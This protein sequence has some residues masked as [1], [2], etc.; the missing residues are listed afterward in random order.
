MIEPDRPVPDRP[1][2][3]DELHAYVDD[4]L[5]PARRAAVER[6]LRANPALQQRIDG[7]QAQSETLRDAL[8]FKAQEPVPA[9]LH[10]GRLLEQRIA[11]RRRWAL[12]RPWRVAAAMLLMLGVGAAGGWTLRGPQRMGEVTRLGME[13]AA[14][15]TVFAADPAHPIEIGP[16]NRP[17]LVAWI[18]RQLHRQLNVP[19]LSTQGYRLVGGRV[20]STM[21][22]PAAMLLYDDGRGVRITIFLQP[23][24]SDVAP[25]QPVRAGAANGYA[26][27]DAHMGYSVISD[28]DGSMHGLADHVRQAMTPE[29]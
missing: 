8:A 5:D 24:R 11:G 17:E 20:L 10:L 12:D 16:E 18:D 22:G 4:R 1:V 27:I 25:M 28:Q 21:I 3:E 14:A 7:W 19:D 13:A 23:M 6:H 29:R 9:S 2:Q 15:H 26:W